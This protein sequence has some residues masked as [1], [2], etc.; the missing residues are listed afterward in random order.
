MPPEFVLAHHGVGIL[1]LVLG[2]FLVVAKVEEARPIEQLD[3]LG[4]Q[5]AAHA[6]I[7]RRRDHVLI[8]TQPGVVCGG[9]VQLRNRLQPEIAATLQLLAQLLR[10]PRVL[11]GDFRVR[12]ITHR[13]AEINHH[14]VQAAALHRL[15]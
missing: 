11:H 3:D 1:R 6:V 4:D 7:L 10:T 2:G 14:H 8:D 15:Q 12:A 9:E 5:L 13:I